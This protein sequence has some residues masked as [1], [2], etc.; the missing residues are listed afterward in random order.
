MILNFLKYNSLY[1]ENEDCLCSTETKNQYR[2]IELWGVVSVKI[3]GAFAVGRDSEI[4]L[5]CCLLWA[6][7]NSPLTPEEFRI[8]KIN[9][10]YLA[11]SLLLVYVS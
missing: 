8:K 2:I 9:C 1:F 7:Q 4:S 5:M 3:F 10:N 6:S 11:C